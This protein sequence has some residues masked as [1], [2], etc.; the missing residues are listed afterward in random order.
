[1]QKL[2]DYLLWLIAL[3]W[4]AMKIW[5]TPWLESI[6]MWLA[7]LYLPI[8]V[9]LLLDA[10]RKTRSIKSAI[11]DNLVEYVGVLVILCLWV[12]YKTCT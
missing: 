2:H 4:F 7:R 6:F 3:S 1:M 5:R 10:W 9:L 11:K 8:L 12:V